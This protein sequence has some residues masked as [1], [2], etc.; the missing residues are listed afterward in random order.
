MRE[1]TSGPHVTSGAGTAHDSP[2]RVCATGANP[3]RP[4]Q[5]QV[6]VPA[7]AR[8]VDD[9]RAVLGSASIS[10]R[11]VLER[12][13]TVCSDI[14]RA[15]IAEDLNK[16]SCAAPSLVNH[17]KRKNRREYTLAE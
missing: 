2:R 17:A 12:V 6:R 10:S 8:A 14:P 1:M 4:V 7:L 15:G 5:E 9:A 13:L 16:G 3:A 11:I